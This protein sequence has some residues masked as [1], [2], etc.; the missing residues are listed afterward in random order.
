MEE[1]LCLP[2]TVLIPAHGAWRA[3]WLLAT[4]QA[5]VVDGGFDGCGHGAIDSLLL[6]TSI[7]EPDSHHLLL[8]GQLLCNHGD[9]F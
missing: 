9:L 7:A 3:A 5:G 6:L 4:H 1:T 8:H 2:G